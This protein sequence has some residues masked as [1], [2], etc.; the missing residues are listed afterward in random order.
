MNF[1]NKQNIILALIS[2]FSY[3]N[4]SVTAQTYRNDGYVYSSNADINVNNFLGNG[5]I[6]SNH[7]LINCDNFG[8]TGTINCDGECFIR[9]KNAFDYKQFTKKGSGKFTVII[10]PY[11]FK[12]QDKSGIVNFSRSLMLGNLLSKTNQTIDSEINRIRY[13]IKIN[14]LNEKEVFNE[15][16]NKLEDQINYH[17]TRLN[18]TVSRPDLATSI[19]L[20]TLSVVGYVVSFAQYRSRV[21]LEKQFPSLPKSEALTW[22]LIGFGASTIPALAAVVYFTEALNP[23]HQEKLN[24]LLGIK[25]RIHK[26]LEQ[27]YVLKNVEIID[28]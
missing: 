18:Q 23:R 28:L 20:S 3:L 10:S 19:A 5:T 12:P 6:S 8:F 25:G 7:V 1:Q 14:S 9:C 2:T 27:P 26:A 22:M 4:A 13:S 24:K 15:L 17:R 16:L 11:E 21:N